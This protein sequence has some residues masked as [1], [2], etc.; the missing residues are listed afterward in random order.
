M[1]SS[2]FT[3]V[4]VCIPL[5]YLYW[6]FI[7]GSWDDFLEVLRYWFQPNLLSLFRGEFGEDFHATLK[8]SFFLILSGG[9]TVLVGFMFFGLGEISA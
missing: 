1:T 9:S 6:R 4:A 7:F 3:C 2:W 5:Y 8:M